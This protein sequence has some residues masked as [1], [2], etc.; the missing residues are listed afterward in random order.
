ME[1]TLRFTLDERDV[2]LVTLTVPE[3]DHLGRANHRS[4]ILLAVDTDRLNTVSA[5]KRAALDTSD[6]SV[7]HDYLT[8]KL[9]A[10]RHDNPVTGDAAFLRRQMVYNKHFKPV[11]IPETRAYFQ[12]GVMHG[13]YK[14]WYSNGKKHEEAHYI[15]DKLMDA[16]PDIPAYRK[17]T[18]G[19]TLCL[20]EHYNNGEPV[21]VVMTDN[22]PPFANK[23]FNDAGQ[24]VRAY[25]AEIKTHYDGRSLDKFVA[26]YRDNGG[27][28]TQCRRDT[29]SPWRRLAVFLGLSGP[30]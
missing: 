28:I 5:K 18:K 3:R 4:R 13:P 7:W 25:D 12:K 30:V 11:W 8:E 6:D 10:F 16:S 15:H 26:L 29:T 17:W 27:D 20:L 19:G 1:T 23:Y 22:L 21:N 24:L 2:T 9:G 14:S